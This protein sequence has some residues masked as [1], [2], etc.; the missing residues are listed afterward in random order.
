V[1]ITGLSVKLP[2]NTCPNSSS[3]R[4]MSD[5]RINSTA[6]AL[7]GFHACQ[8]NSFLSHKTYSCSRIPDRDT[9]L[10]TL[11]ILRHL[12]CLDRPLGVPQS[13][14]QRIKV[15][16]SCRPRDWTSISCPKSTKSLVKEL[17][18]DEKNI[19]WCPHMHEQDELA[20]I[21]RY[22]FQNYWQIIKQKPMTPCTC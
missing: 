22:V 10:V 12:P 16:G 19:F 15:R 2:V 18:K 5:V 9:A 21:K 17:S 1:V 13:K 4:D 3:C 7:C 11:R 6:G 8:D 20:L 14:I